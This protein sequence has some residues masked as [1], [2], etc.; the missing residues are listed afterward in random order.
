MAWLVW[1]DKSISLVFAAIAQDSAEE[2]EAADHATE[3][4]EV[5]SQDCFTCHSLLAMEEEEPEI[6]DL[7]QP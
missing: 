2:K 7:L 4:G 6:L 1:M 3:D 5:I